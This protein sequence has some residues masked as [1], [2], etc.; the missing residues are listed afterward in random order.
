MDSWALEPALYRIALAELGE[1]GLDLWLRDE[2]AR[3]ALLQHKTL[4]KH[5]PR[6]AGGPLL[7]RLCGLLM[8]EQVMPAQRHQASGI[9]LAAV[10]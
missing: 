5:F 9:G 4:T 8:G 3:H 10:V 7:D 6:I 2:H 1:R